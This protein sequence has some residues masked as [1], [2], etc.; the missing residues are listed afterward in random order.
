MDNF[1]DIDLLQVI[2]AFQ[3]ETFAKLNV[4]RIGIIEEVLADNEVRCSITNK[5]LIKTNPDGTSTWR[6]YPP[7]FAKVWY[8]GSGA[9][10][11]DYPLTVNTPCLLLFNDREFNSYFDSKKVSPLSNTLMHDLSYC[12]CVPLYQAVSDSNVNIKSATNLNLSA[13]TALNLSATTINITASAVN[14]TGTLTINGQP[15]LS[16]THSNGNLGSPTGGVII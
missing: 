4:M 10:G 7:I 6:D 1:N 9:S 15:Y 5:K 8:M 14:I 13:T 16:H 3:Q 2:R 12:I 11:I